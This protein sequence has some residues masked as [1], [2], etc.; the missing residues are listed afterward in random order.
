LPALI[1]P[2]CPGLFSALNDLEEN[3][4][5]EVFP[6]P[7]ESILT[8]RNLKSGTVEFYNTIGNLM[9]TSRVSLELKQ[10]YRFDLSGWPSGVY[11]IRNG[12]VTHKVLKQ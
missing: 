10:E 1:R 11:L 3:P 6:N 8:A 9:L 7:V 4:H 2:P 12:S 5:L